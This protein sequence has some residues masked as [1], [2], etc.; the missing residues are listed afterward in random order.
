MRVKMEPGGGRGQLVQEQP[1]ILSTMAS[2]L[3]CAALWAGPRRTTKPNSIGCKISGQTLG[4]WTSNQN[5]VAYKRKDH[6][7]AL[8]GAVTLSHALRQWDNDKLRE[9][10]LGYNEVG[11]DGACQIA[12]VRQPAR[13]DWG[14][15]GWGFQV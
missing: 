14:A 7:A 1:Q 12:R 15:Q 4:T 2:S 5:S 6:I 10:D 11:D 8:A 9:L 13:R 3:L